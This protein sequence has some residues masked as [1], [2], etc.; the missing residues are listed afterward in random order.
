VPAGAT[1][2]G[3]PA[4]IIM[5]RDAQQREENAARMGFSAYAVNQNADDPLAIALHG[6][7]DHAAKQ[8]KQIVL[9]IAALDKLGVCPEE[10]CGDENFD[11]K[12][13]ND[14]VD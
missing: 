12:K 1:A 13:L 7:I 14:L 6:L 3:I 5:E 4:R 9:M 2:V 10:I 11:P 8:D